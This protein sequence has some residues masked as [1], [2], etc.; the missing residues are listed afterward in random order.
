MMNK[1]I[2]LIIGL[3]ALIIVTLFWVLVF[4]SKD[5]YEAYQSE[6]EE[7][8]ESPNRVTEKEGISTVALSPETQ[9]NSGITYS[10]VQKIAYQGVVK[11]YGSVISIDKL[12]EAKSQYIALSTELQI[13]KSSSQ[14]LTSQFQR[15]KTLNED[16][17]NI[18]DSAV[19]EAQSQLHANQAKIQALVQQQQ[20]LKSTV[21]L[22]WGEPLTQLVVGGQGSPQ[23]N[24]L[25][26]RQ[27]VLVQVSLPITAN[28]PAA[29]D[30]IQI[31][32][33]N[34]RAASVKALYI[35]PASTADISGIGKT[36]YYSAPAESLRVGMRVHVVQANRTQLQNEGVVIPSSAVVWHAGKPWVYVKQKNNQFIRQPISTDTEIEEGWFN[37]NIAAGSQVV[38]SG[39]QLL[40]SEE[41]KYLIKNENED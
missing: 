15:L 12:V 5:E 18:S 40:L 33:L 9:A 37:Q 6:Q 38:T 31:I 22:Q 3:Q 23:V 32:S 36:Y 2:T 30:S 27:N 41:F 19:Q 10:K 35:S 29:G 16:D 1:K 4:Y 25:L 13:A 11:T 17:K 28:T 26:T 8:I 7:E 20:N 21:Q 24:Q 34:E 39:A 14:Q